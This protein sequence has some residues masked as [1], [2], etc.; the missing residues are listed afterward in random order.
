MRASMPCFPTTDFG[1]PDGRSSD[2]PGTRSGRARGEDALRSLHAEA[3]LEAVEL[4]LQL[5]RE[6][7]AELGEPLL[8]LRDL[9][10]PLV[11]VDRERLLELG[12]A[13]VEPRGV[14]RLRRRHVADRGLD[15][16]GLALDALDGP[17]EDA[18]VLAEP[19]PQE[20]TVVAATE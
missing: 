17:L 20:V 10:L 4:H 2:R 12:V 5:G 13:H 1:C 14:E 8:D 11:G 7:L 15:G 19:G 9:G 16:R 6:V 18:A 3:R